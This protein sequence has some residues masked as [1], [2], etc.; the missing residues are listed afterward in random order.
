[1]EVISLIL[2]PV[3]CTDEE[4]GGGYGG[5][6]RDRILLTLSRHPNPVQNIAKDLVLYG[7]GNQGGYGGS[8]PYFAFIVLANII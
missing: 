7:G 3:I 8:F 6:A 4:I 5:G 1:M 2:E